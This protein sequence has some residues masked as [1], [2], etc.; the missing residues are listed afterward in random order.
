MAGD[1]A[2]TLEEA[3]NWMKMKE[4]LERIPVYEPKQ[5]ET[6]IIC[7]HCG[8]C[9]SHEEDRVDG[10][11]KCCKGIDTTEQI[12]TTKGWFDRKFLEEIKA[13]PLK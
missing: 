6:R 1:N 3:E 2:F 7:S 8:C 5:F 11:C 9:A 13:I 10:Q 4:H 12:R